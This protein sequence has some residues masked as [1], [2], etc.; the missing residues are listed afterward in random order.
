[1]FHRKAIACSRAQL[2]ITSQRNL[3]LMTPFDTS[4]AVCYYD[5]ER[6]ER[7]PSMCTGD[8]NTQAAGVAVYQ[9]GC[10]FGAVLILFY[11]ETWGRKSSTFWG[12]GNSKPELLLTLTHI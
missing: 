11:G 8:A 12:V 3:P 7:N 6:T 1:M 4:N 5:V 9:I 2:I 10:F